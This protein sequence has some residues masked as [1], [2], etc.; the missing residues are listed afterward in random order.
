MKQV[1]EDLLNSNQLEGKYS[2]YFKIGQNA[3]EFVIEF[4]QYYPEK[5]K[6]IFHTRIITSP[7]YAKSLL[8]ILQKTIKRYEQTFGKIV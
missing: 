7:T 2:N 8:E 5:E 3:F 4:G 1:P 6:E